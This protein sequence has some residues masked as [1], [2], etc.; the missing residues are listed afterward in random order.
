MT[1]WLKPEGYAL[2][3][4]RIGRLMRPA[5]RVGSAIYSKP[6][7][8]RP[9]LEHRVYTPTLLRGLDIARPNH[10]RVMGITYIP[11]RKGFFVYLVLGLPGE[12]CLG[13]CP[14]AWSADFCIEAGEEALRCCGKPEIFNAQGSQFTG[15]ELVG[16][17]QIHG[18]GGSIAGWTTRSSKDFGKT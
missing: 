5:D 4:K 16:L 3:R 10:V 9:Q 18:S 15:N 11:M 17:I 13:G 6:N 7:F 12:S 2:N 1:A 14:P 8:S